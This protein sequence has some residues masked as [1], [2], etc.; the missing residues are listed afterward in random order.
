MTPEPGSTSTSRSFSKHTPTAKQDL[1]VGHV[2]QRKMSSSEDDSEVPEQVSLSTSKQQ[3][4][5]RTKD[6]AKE[7]AQVVSKRKER[8]REKDRQLKQRS[9]KQ[10]TE[11][12]RDVKSSPGE[13]EQSRDPRLLP[14]HLF[15]AAFNQPSSAPGPSV[16][17]D[18]PQKTQQRKR[19]RTYLT[20]K[21]QIIG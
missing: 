18:T 20:P 7:L 10:G 4:I 8:N 17:S 3:V 6:V 21:D 14:D 16:P 5:G 13:D 15:T 2:R 11:P 9:S 1:R 19:K 12:T